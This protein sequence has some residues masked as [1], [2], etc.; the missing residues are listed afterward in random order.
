MEPHVRVT[1]YL[2]KL[3]IWK[4]FSVSLL[5]AIFQ[6][7]Q[8]NIKSRQLRK[9]PRIKFQTK[10][11]LTNHFIFE[12]EIFLIRG[13]IQHCAQALRKA[14]KADI[15]HA[16]EKHSVQRSS[17]AQHVKRRKK[18]K[19]IPQP[20]QD[21]GKTTNNTSDRIPQ[22]SGFDELGL[23]KRILLALND[24]DFQNCTPIQAQVLPHTLK[25]RDAFGKAQTGTGKTAAFLLTILQRFLTSVSERGRKP[26]ALVLAP[27][28]ELAIQ[29]GNDMGALCKYTD[30]KYTAVYGGAGY[31][32]Q[33][34]ALE[35][36]TDVVI[37]TPGRLLDYIR[38]RKVDLSSVEI[39][40][41]D[42]A[43]RMLDMGFIPDV[44]YI[45]SRLPATEKRQNLLFSAT[46]SD[47]IVQLASKWMHDPIQVE[48]EPKQ[49][50]PKEVVQK[51][52][53]LAA[54]DKLAMLLSLLKHEASERVLV[55]RNRRDASE[56]LT[57]QLL[58][59]G[60][61][62]ALLSGDVRQKKRIQVLEAFRAGRIRVIVATDVAARGIHVEDISHVINYDLPYEAEDYVH[63]IG[64]TGR[65]GE[66]GQAV[67]FVCEEGGF[68]IPEIEEFIKQPLTIEQ[69]DPDML[70]LPHPLPAIKRTQTDQ[71]V[72]RL[73]KTNRSR[74][75]TR[76]SQ[77]RR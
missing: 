20:V 6:F 35:S 11:Q 33:Q 66:T 57:H 52:Y 5:Q 37:A 30:V 32:D 28:R 68:V 25:G 71:H 12:T 31:Q 2:T 16:Q 13:L 4:H 29:I 56:K 54:Q 38:G 50:V 26:M 42:E 53:A 7:F 23:D 34:N 15:N 60:I 58:H 55:F 22:K 3:L 47:D 40:V 48:I 24:L 67:S 45:L 1:C 70:K 63:R 64:R 51:A 72:P 76:H 17:K 62:C 41:I 39:L 43:D 65:A 61:K 10:T 19:H 77:K 69:P 27:T 74:S 75:Q 9:I 14:P 8:G 49:I 36:G 46:I 44:R 73:R 21:T 18:K 59:Y